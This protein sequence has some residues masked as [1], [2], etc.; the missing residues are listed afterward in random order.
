YLG[1][2]NG[3][4]GD[5]ITYSNKVIQSGYTLEP[6]Y[7]H[8]F[9]ADND[10]RRNEI[11]L[12]INYDAVNSQNYGGTTFL[13]NSSTNSDMDPA[14]LGILKGGWG[15]N[16]TNA[17]LVDK[18]DDLT[19]ASD[20]RAMFFGDNPVIQDISLFDQ[21]IAVMKFKNVDRDGNAAASND[22]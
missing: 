2:G 22:D 19:G 13:I 16:R 5:A 9:L 15:G 18:F 7:A 1:E 10:Q 17:S 14:S 6:T 20:N 8:L 12:S 11:I 4:Y 21:G 3:M